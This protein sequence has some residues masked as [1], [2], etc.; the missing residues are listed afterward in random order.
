MILGGLK[1]N[2]LFKAESTMNSEQV[3]QGFAH[4]KYTLTVAN[5]FV[6]LCA[7]RSSFQADLFKDFFREQTEV[8]SIVS[9]YTFEYST[10]AFLQSSGASLLQSLWPFKNDK[11]TTLCILEGVLLFPAD[12]D[13]SRCLRISS[14]P[15]LFFLS[16]LNSDSRHKETSTN[17]GPSN[18]HFPTVHTVTGNWREATS[19][20]TYTPSWDI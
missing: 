20:I 11:A 8:H 15:L 2:L 16:S 17:Q 6:F 7:P 1:S 12:F 18:Q 4:N 10:F 13:G 19:C 5:Y 9:L 14:F 3:V